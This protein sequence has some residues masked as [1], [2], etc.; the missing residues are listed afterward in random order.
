M[1]TQTPPA[2][3]PPDTTETNPTGADSLAETVTVQ[4]QEAD[5]ETIPELQT[6]DTNFPHLKSPGAA[7]ISSP[8]H[9]PS[10]Q[11]PGTP[12]TFVWRV[13]STPETKPSDKGKDKLKTPSS[14]SAPITRQGY[15]SGRLADDFWAALN[16]P[17]TPH[18]QKKKLKVIPFITKNHSFTEYLV[19]NSTQPFTSITSV[20]IAELLAGVPWTVPR[21][22]QHIVNEIAH[23][24]HKVLVF[25]NQHTTPFQAWSQGHWFSHWTRAADGDHTCTLFVSI[26]VPEHKIK[27]RKGRDLSWR[28]IP[29]AAK[30]ALLR[31][32]TEDVQEAQE[33][34][35]YWKAMACGRNDPSTSSHAPVPTAPNPFSVL[36]EEN[37]EL[38]S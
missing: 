7:P 2:S 15:R 12:L 5:N 37:E 24:L 29:S 11:V 8:P 33:A 36:R 1:I 34:G 4:T 19:D 20:H 17:E 21:A 23:A 10:T 6:N 35:L 14:E 30:E 18:S 27:I 9:S 16:I 38:S 25:N 26:A 13:K 22:R 28:A 31:V 3:I 32:E